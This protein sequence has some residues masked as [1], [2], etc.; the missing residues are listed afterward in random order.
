MD[1]ERDLY[2]VLLTNRVN[3]TRDNQKHISLRRA[4][5]DAVNLSITDMPTIKREW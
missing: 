5:S 3:P 2:I 1:P 4:I